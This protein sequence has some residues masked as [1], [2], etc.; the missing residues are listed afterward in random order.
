MPDEQ[1]PNMEVRAFIAVLL[2][3]GVML[4]YQYFFAPEPPDP[5]LPAAAELAP[6]TEP[7]TPRLPA[8]T[9]PRGGDE[10]GAEGGGA[11]PAEVASPQPI[12]ADSRRQ[13]TIE[14]ERYELTLDNRGALIIGAVLRGFESDFNG[15]L[16]LVVDTP[17]IDLPGLLALASPDDPSVAE[18]FNQALYE[19]TI[20]GVPAGSRHRADGLTEIRWLWADGTGWSVDK[21]LTVNPEGYLNLVRVSVVTPRQTEVF[22]TVGPGL[23]VGADNSR[24]GIYLMKGA[25]YFDGADVT[26]VADDDIEAQQTITLDQLTW[27]GIQSNYFVAL[28][29][30]DRRAA[31]T[32]M[33]A[34]A[35]V[36]D[37]A[38]EGDE[39]ADEG[40]PGTLAQ[41]GLRVPPDGALETPLFLGPKAFEELEAAG[42]GLERAVDYGI[43]AILARPVAMSLE[44]LSE[45]VGNY[46]LAIILATLGV[47]LLFFPLSQSSMK[48]MRK[49]QQWQPQMNAIRAKYKGVKDMQKR[50]EMNTEVM[51]LYKDNGVSPLGGCVP[52]VLQMPVLFAFY[53]AISVSMAARQAPLGLW[54]QDLSKMDPYYVLPL[55]MGVAMFAQQR[56]SPSTGDPMQ[57]RI[58]RLMPVMFTFFF[59]TFPSG[60]VTYWLVNTVLGI[61]QQ[62][63]VNHQLETPDAKAT[64]SPKKKNKKKTGKGRKGGGA[65][66][67]KRGKK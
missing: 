41:F 47:R 49:M 45:R 3:L 6:A 55:L 29:A 22:L 48:S 39:P 17:Q 8:D 34:A 27:G 53:A 28:F 64:S 50:Q 24:A 18:R 62:G 54:I 13:L 43:F 21:R 16:Q 1:G 30:P 20:D 25:V 11:E 38:A 35:A 58:F 23:E 52:M 32:V 36:P 63:Y 37:E 60:L 2:S 33:L 40:G 9:E 26:H 10:T 42:F 57:Q 12:G 66:R 59:L 5:T 56:M 51:Q 46:G 19:V 31:T 67:S 7:S 15:P 14:T 61:A 65:K 44:W 4:G